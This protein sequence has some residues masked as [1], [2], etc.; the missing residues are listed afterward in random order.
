MLSSNEANKG[1]ML[2][3]VGLYAMISS[4]YQF[5]GGYYEIRG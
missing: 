5:M 3:N 2:E 4:V 1:R